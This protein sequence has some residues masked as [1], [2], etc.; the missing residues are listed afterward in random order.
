MFQNVPGCSMFRVL[1]T[2]ENFSQVRPMPQRQLSPKVNKFSPSMMEIHT[3]VQ[4]IQSEWNQHIETGN[5]KCESRHS[6]FLAQ[7][8]NGKPS[9]ETS[10]P[11]ARDF[12]ARGRPLRG[13][14]MLAPLAKRSTCSNSTLAP[15]TTKLYTIEVQVSEVTSIWF[16]GTMWLLSQGNVEVFKRYIHDGKN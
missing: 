7:N 12:V 15:E 10:R 9:S 4:Q 11:L 8:G 6:P 3:H 13:Q 1:S 5:P 14:T 2:P 16:I